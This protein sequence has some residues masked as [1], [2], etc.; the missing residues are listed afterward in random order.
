MLCFRRLK[1][2]EKRKRR[3]FWVHVY[4]LRAMFQLMFTHDCVSIKRLLWEV[5]WVVATEASNDWLHNQSLI[6]TTSTCSIRL[7]V[8]FNRTIDLFQ[9]YLIT[10]LMYHQPYDYLQPIAGKHRSSTTYRNT[11]SPM[12]SCRLVV[13]RSFVTSRTISKSLD[14]VWLGLYFFEA[15]DPTI[16]SEVCVYP[17]SHGYFLQELWNWLLFVIYAIPCSNILPRSPAYGVYIS[18]MIRYTRTCFAY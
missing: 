12:K 18:W 17:F 14:P 1:R 13:F 9:F 2:H 5:V 4:S 6:A 8:I 3:E 15:L 11:R 16:F 7:L 10:W